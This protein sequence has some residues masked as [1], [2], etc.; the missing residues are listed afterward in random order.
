MPANLI[1]AR[2]RRFFLTYA[3]RV[4]KAVKR[5]GRFGHV[6]HLLPALRRL[7][8]PTPGL[9]Y[10]QQLLARHGRPGNIDQTPGR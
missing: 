1:G 2:Q 3:G 10:I 4:M 5:G 7:P 6:D 8:S 9:K